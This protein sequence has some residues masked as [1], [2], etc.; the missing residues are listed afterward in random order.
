MI[1][2]KAI[3]FASLVTFTSN[4]YAYNS[5]QEDHFQISLTNGYMTNQLNSV[6]ASGHE[7]SNAKLYHQ[8]GLGY[9]MMLGR[10]FSITP[11]LKAGLGFNIGEGAV[12]NH[13]LF[14]AQS[15]SL[16]KNLTQIYTGALNMRGYFT[17]HHTLFA[18]LTPSVDVHISDRFLTQVTQIGVESGLGIGLSEGWSL[19][20]GYQ[21][22]FVAFSADSI[23]SMAPE[24]HRHQIKLNLAYDF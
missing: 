11:T 4:G 20:V 16:T 1:Q 14:A 12:R 15:S 23:F 24:H 18:Y 17:P 6:D 5:N 3:I 2:K 22:G 9:L 21:Y 10:H 8:V 19:E 7:S 13:G